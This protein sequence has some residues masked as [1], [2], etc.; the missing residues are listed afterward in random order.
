MIQINTP[1]APALPI[2]QQ[3]YT[4]IY[5]DTFGNVLRLYF[6]QLD[7]N[8][9]IL[10]TYLNQLVNGYLNLDYLQLNASPL[11]PHEHNPGR[12]HWDAE[13]A[14]I[15]A[16]MEYGVTQQVGQETYA[17][18]RNSTGVD[19]PN[20]TVV[21]FAGASTDALNVAPYLADGSNPSLYI[22]GIMT[23]DL[24]DSG[25]KG[26]CTTW[27]FVRELDTS[28]FSVGD[29]LYASPTVAGALTNVK[30]T[31]PNNVIPVAAVVKVGLTDGVIFVRPT[32]QQM[33]Y[34]G[35]FTKTTDQSPAATNT[36]Y[37][38]TFDNTQV[39]NGVTIGSPTSRIV[40]PV[41]GLYQFSATIQLSSGSAA[42]K[43]V[44]VWFRKNGVDITNSAR[45]V[46]IDLNGGYVPI[47]VDEFF[48]LNVG[49]YVEIIFAADS[50]SITVDSVASTAFA[51][52]APAVVLSVTQV[53]Q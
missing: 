11:I 14:T 10:S 27:G 2:A 12:I 32:I 4:K 48:S 13:D 36:A 16:D 49:D 29:I 46:T 21:G 47:I 30:P 17:R 15:E 3:Q 34:Y 42:A 41:S 7:A 24:P 53:Q 43:T 40:V 22:L 5:Q 45:L 18:V 20:G 33:Q 50:T 6:N 39:S 35:I 51:P 52:A 37:E 23:H 9:Q 28:G 26:Y 8:N 31:A 44:W 19:I 38:L 1:K 25:E